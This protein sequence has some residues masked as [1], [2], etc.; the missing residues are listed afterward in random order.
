MAPLA[1]T[2][3]L[4]IPAHLRSMLVAVV[5]AALLAVL[6]AGPASASSKGCSVKNKATGWDYSSLQGAVNAAKPKAT[7]LVRGTCPEKT[8]IRRD[9][10][11]KGV[12]GLGR[13]VAHVGALTIE[14]GARAT[15]R[16]LAIRNSRV[17]NRGIATFVDVH[18]KGSLNPWGHGISNTGVLRLQG[19]SWVRLTN[20]VANRGRLTLGG[21][22]HIR[23][24]WT[25][26]PPSPVVLNT[27]T[28]VMNDRSN[29][30][31]SERWGDG[32]QHSHLV[33]KGRLV[34]NHHSS[35]TD[36]WA[37]GAVHNHGTM[38]M[39]HHSSVHRNGSDALSLS[40]DGLRGGGIRNLGTLVMRNRSSIHDN[41]LN[42]Y[43]LCDPMTDRAR[44]AGVYNSGTF[45]MRDGSSIRGNGPGPVHT[46]PPEWVTGG[47][48][49]N[50]TGGTLVGV[51][52]GPGGNVYGNTP[53]D[54][55]FAE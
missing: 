26:E 27:G 39:N 29:I 16:S 45:V 14:R 7:L 6:I 9:V 41:G 1:F 52:C 5:A 35:L 38:V 54:C 43:E 23:R 34:M 20:G 2:G 12:P 24:N 48:I 40:C 44:G 32:E 30:G 17:V 51:T 55:Y 21:T 13:A 53:D 42:W 18:V 36:G 49:F 37:S 46:G 31:W 19:H 3:S 50:D 28:I 47:G 4:D 10:R 8:V 33:N 22:S 25:E 11:V 15:V